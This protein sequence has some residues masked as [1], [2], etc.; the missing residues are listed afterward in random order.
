[1]YFYDPVKVFFC[2][3]C[4]SDL[5]YKTRV[6]ENGEF[7]PHETKRK[8]FISYRKKDNKFNLLE[9]VAD[10]I[11][12]AA[13]CA[14]WYDLS[15]T[16][17]ERYDDE[18]SAAIKECDA[19]VLLLTEDVLS[20][21]YIWNIEIRSA[22]EYKKGII[23]IALG[24]ATDRYEAVTAKIG[25][26]H[27]LSGE[28]VFLKELKTSE[29]EKE[30]KVF[31]EAL[32]RSIYRFVIN[33][34]IAKKVSDFFATKRNELPFRY[35]T[36]D[37]IYLF[38]YGLLNGLS[39]ENNADKAL[40]ILDSLIN[41]YSSDEE[42]EKLKGVIAFDL[43]MYYMKINDIST[44][45]E[46]GEKAILYKSV[47]ASDYL[48]QLYWRGDIVKADKEKALSCLLFGADRNNLSSLRLLLDFLLSKNPAGNQ[49]KY[50][51]MEP[52]YEKAA[53]YG[54]EWDALNLL[55]F[56]WNMNEYD[57]IN[58]LCESS[59]E[60][61]VLFADILNKIISSDIKGRMQILKTAYNKGFEDW[62]LMHEISCED[63]KFQLYK[64]RTGKNTSDVSLV[65]DNKAVIYTEKCVWSHGECPTFDIWEDAG[66]LFLKISDF[67]HYSVETAVKTL[68]IFNPLAENIVTLSYFSDWVKGRHELKF[69]AYIS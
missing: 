50:K 46:Y 43:M 57:K 22:I 61:N 33:Q 2:M 54:E 42:T 12:K 17:G 21:D 58:R 15:L 16:P 52:Y 39:T 68:S 60:M 28:E 65:R 13:D 11:L 14:V 34:N 30:E 7:E 18:I 59:K 4:S 27:F 23:P 26:I 56:Y 35:L 9:R 63:H 10:F 8:V 49:E 31:I 69:S 1:M 3:I 67:D 66:C 6:D 44:A 41:L 47:Q 64:I 62:I 38:A 20:S 32:Q 19:V 55:S 29:N 40:G 24:L 48:G 45:L 37:Q 5:R 36:V 25:N 53:L 51:A